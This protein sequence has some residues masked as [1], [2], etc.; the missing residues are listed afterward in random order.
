MPS[1]RRSCGHAELVEEHLGPLVGMGRQHA[2]HEADRPLAVVGDEQHV[3][4]VGEERGRRRRV[5]RAVE[6]VLGGEHRV[7]VS[8]AERADLDGHLREAIGTTP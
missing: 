7:V 8:E 5:G 3:A 1:R 6:Q 4:L 2:R